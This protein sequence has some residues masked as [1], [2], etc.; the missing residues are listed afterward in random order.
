M[1]ENYEQILKRKMKIL[2]IGR[3]LQNVHIKQFIFVLNLKQ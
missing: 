2:F 1:V 3:T